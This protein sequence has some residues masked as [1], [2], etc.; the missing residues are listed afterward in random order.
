MQRNS[1]APVA[2]QAEVTLK[3]NFFGTLNVCNELFPLLRQHARFVSLI[4]LLKLPGFEGPFNEA[5][6]LTY[7]NLAIMF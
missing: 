1:T 5:L 6:L 4:W 2:E 3:T 7:A